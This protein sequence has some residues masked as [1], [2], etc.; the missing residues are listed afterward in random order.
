MNCDTLERNPG[1]K[2]Y[3]RDDPSA[4]ALEAAKDAN[5]LVPKLLVLIEDPCLLAGD[6]KPLHCVGTNF[7]HGAGTRAC[8][9]KTCLGNFT[10]AALLKP[11]DNLLPRYVDGDLLLDRENKS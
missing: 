1:P 6:Q 3:H 9:P 7:L 10:N 4:F 8:P 11:D 2:E 5:G